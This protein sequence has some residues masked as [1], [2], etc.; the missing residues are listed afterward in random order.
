MSDLKRSAAVN[1]LNKT[2]K[3]QLFSSLLRLLIEYQFQ[4]D[5]LLSAVPPAGRPGCRTA[6]LIGLS[7]FQSWIE[8][9]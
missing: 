6:L 3:K 9:P 8:K 7:V 5:E 4:F 2:K 1:K